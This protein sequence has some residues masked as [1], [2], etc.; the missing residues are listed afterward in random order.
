M[1]K[2]INMDYIESAL[3][4]M[5]PGKE[6][7]RYNV[8]PFSRVLFTIGGEKFE[9]DFVFLSNLFTAM[10]STFGTL[11]RMWSMQTCRILHFK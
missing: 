5:F 8:V 9:K 2:V 11:F 10:C 6:V 7:N 4:N 1:K 3:A